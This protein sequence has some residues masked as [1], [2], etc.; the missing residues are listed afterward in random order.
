M[1]DCGD[2]MLSVNEERMLET[3]RARP[4]STLSELVSA[5]ADVMSQRDAVEAL[6]WLR[7]RRNIAMKIEVFELTDREG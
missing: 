1:M 6:V 3:L 2:P 7:T 5:V 4:R